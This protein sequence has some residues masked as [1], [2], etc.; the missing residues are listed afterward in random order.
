MNI[1][2]LSLPGENAAKLGVDFSRVNA[3][4]LSHG[5]SDHGG[6][7]RTFL[8]QN[9]RAEANAHERPLSRNLPTV[10]EKSE[11]TSAGCRLEINK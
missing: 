6:L 11:P 7:L 4:T 3:A 8:N 2:V 5:H 9:S 1:Q 10:Q